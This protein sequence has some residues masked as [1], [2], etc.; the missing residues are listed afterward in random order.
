M[1][2]H[3]I[4]LGLGA[5]LTMAASAQNPYVT[6]SVNPGSQVIT[7]NQTYT[8]NLTITS[9]LGWTGWI[10]PGYLSN[11]NTGQIACSNPNTGVYFYTQGTLTPSSANL[12][13]N[14]SA[15]FTFTGNAI[16][17]APVSCSFYFTASDINGNS[18][19]FNVALRPQSWTTMFSPTPPGRSIN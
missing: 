8:F 15:T 5:L 13:A 1:K 14:S 18:G 11:G 16:S 12:P 17:T 10:Y 6:A 3:G 19:L 9:Q 7:V 2:R 4:C